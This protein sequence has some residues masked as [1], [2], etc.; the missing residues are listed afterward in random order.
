MLINHKKVK[1]TIIE[2]GIPFVHFARVLRINGRQ[3]HRQQIYRAL[4]VGS[5][6]TLL[7]KITNHLIVILNTRYKSNLTLDYFLV[8]K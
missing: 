6:K 7:L 1:E 8:K 3:R 5:D 2:Y 4:T